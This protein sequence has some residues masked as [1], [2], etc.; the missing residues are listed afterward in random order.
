MLHISGKSLIC[1]EKCIQKSEKEQFAKD[2]GSKLKADPVFFIS[3]AGVTERKIVN[4]DAFNANSLMD[5]IK[6]GTVDN[7]E[8]IF[9]IYTKV[10]DFDGSHVKVISAQDLLAFYESKNKGARRRDVDIY[11]LVEFLIQHYP[12][13]HFI[14]DECPFLAEY[15]NEIIKDE[16]YGDSK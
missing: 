15:S 4:H 14:L 7:D 2:V 12:N 9:D 3:L 11:D 8:Y 10:Y 1:K 16:Y 13:G 6:D 5:V